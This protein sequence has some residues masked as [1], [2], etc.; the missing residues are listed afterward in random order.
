MTNSSQ[1]KLCL[2]TLLII[3]KLIIK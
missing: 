3:T 2:H 1:M